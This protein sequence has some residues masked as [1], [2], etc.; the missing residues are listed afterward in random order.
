MMAAKRNTLGLNCVFLVLLPACVAPV[1]QEA[2][3]DHL[4][5][6]KFGPEAERVEVQTYD[7]VSL[8]GVFLP[9]AGKAPVMLHFLP[10]EGSVTSG[11]QG[12]AGLAETLTGLQG[13]GTA[14]LICDYRGVGA[15]GGERDPRCLESDAWFLWQEAL[16]RAG[17]DPARVLLRGVSIGTLA[18]ASLLHQGANPGAAVMI[19]PVRSETIGRH[20]VHLRHGSV[21]GFLLSPFLRRPVEVDLVATL[22]RSRVPILI[23][24]A[25]KDPYLP[26]EELDLVQTAAERGGHR[27]KVV[28]GDHSSL[29]L[30]AYGFEI[31]SYAG[32]LAPDLLPEEA[33]FWQDFR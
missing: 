24:A 19:A 14:S 16:Q 30:R 13:Q 26:A 22:E 33:T 28:P 7:Q 17:G 11:I 20:G 18:V 27:L 12:F 29:V 10:S 1:V 6:G 31:S 8:Q 9:G 3:T 2:G 4:D 25:E 5:L 32:K 23:L 15:S 21:V